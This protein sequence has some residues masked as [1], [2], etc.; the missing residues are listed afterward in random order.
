MVYIRF[1]FS[2]NLEKTLTPEFSMTPP[3]ILDPSPRRS[4]Q[5]REIKIILPEQL[6]ERLLK[7]LIDI[8]AGNTSEDL[9]SE[10][11]QI[12]Y[13]L[14]LAKQISKK[15]LQEILEI[16]TKISTFKEQQKF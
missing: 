12:V 16:S 10:I 6:L 14:Y 2:D 15:R 1:S 8:K 11:R 13:S 3:I 7:L 4:T 5:G 9:L